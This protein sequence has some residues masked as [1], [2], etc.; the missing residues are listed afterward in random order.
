MSWLAIVPGSLADAALYFLSAAA[1][2]LVYRTTATGLFHLAQ[3][4]VMLASVGVF[5][6]SIHS[7]LPFPVAVSLALIT[8]ALLSVTVELSVYGV[9]RARNAAADAYLLASFGL[10]VVLQRVVSIWLGT[11]PLHLPSHQQISERFEIV[12]A[13]LTRNE[14]TSI[15]ISVLVVVGLAWLIRGR[16]G[17]GLE[18]VRQSRLLYDWRGGSSS[19]LLVGLAALS[20]SIAGLAAVLDHVGHRINL[21][22]AAF[23][24]LIPAF[25]V[26]LATQTATERLFLLV[27][28]GR[29]SSALERVAMVVGMWVTAVILGVT[30]RL[31][32][33]YGNPGWKDS[34]IL[35]VAILCLVTLSGRR[36]EKGE[37]AASA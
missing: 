24:Y 33:L 13:Q 25:V 6:R 17:E 9:L 14:V 31:T 34:L 28:A 7:G 37:E 2:A 21:G 19:G 16:L 3:G 10:L 8:G 20:G 29:R 15:G 22:K 26:V 12:G 35:M 30:G 5:N 18:A 23:G 4:G 27:P 11:A 1:F 36:A 32:I